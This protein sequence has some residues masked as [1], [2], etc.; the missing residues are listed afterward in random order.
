MRRRPSVTMVAMVATAGLTLSAC[1]SVKDRA[2]DSSGTT[3]ITM[4]THSAGN[5]EELAQIKTIVKD[6][7]AAH[8][9]YK[10]VLESFP[11]DAYNDAVVAG[12]AAKDLPCLLDMDGPIVSNW[13]WAGYIQPLELDKALTDKLLPSARGT[14]KDKLYSVGYWD[15]SLGM[16]AQKSVLKKNGI[17]VAT[18]EEPWTAEEFDAALVKLKKAGFKYPLD[19]GTGWSGEWWAYGYSPLLQSQGGDLI[20]RDT[21]K[22]ADGALN[23]AESVKFFTWFQSVFKRGLANKAESE[24]REGFN[25]GSVP[26]SWTGGWTAMDSLKKYGDDLAI[27]PPPDF[28]DGPHVGGASWQWGIS[29][30]CEGKAAEGAQKYLAFSLDKKYLA[31]FSD[32]TAVIPATDEAAAISKN[33]GSDG[34]LKIFQEFSKKYTVVRPETPAYPVISSTFE[35]T[36][37]DIM[38]GADV[39][40]ALDQAVKEIDANIASNDDYGF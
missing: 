3:K 7:N 29:S 16:F 24:A 19:L 22:T 36:A 13:A 28:G 23:G 35:K 38:N 32:A 10:V 18:V 31:G 40:K 21:Y 17:R 33:Y 39:K 11:Q 25:D 37:K 26:L 5:A 30:Q 9:A 34:K 6:F 15:V 20:D 1:G 2:E 8:P 4:W 14:F 27:M 12:A